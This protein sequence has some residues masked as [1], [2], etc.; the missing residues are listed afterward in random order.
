MKEVEFKK[1]YK[2]A[3]NRDYPNTDAFMEQ[4]MNA[5]A[6]CAYEKKICTMA[7][8]AYVFNYQTMMMN[9]ERDQQAVE[10]TYH[11]YKKNVKIID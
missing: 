5:L 3:E 11:Y 8:A 4:A 2:M 9:G 1:V 10:E 7:Q 6:G